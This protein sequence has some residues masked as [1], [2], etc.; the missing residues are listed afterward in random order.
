MA[1]CDIR[2]RMTSESIYIEYLPFSCDPATHIQHLYFDAAITGGSFKLAVNGNVTA[3]INLLTMPVASVNT[4]VGDTVGSE[5]DDVG[6]GLVVGDKVVFQ[7]TG[8]VLPAPLTVDTLYYV[9]AVPTVDSFKVSATSGGTAITITTVGTGTSSWNKLVANLIIN[10][11]TA[12]DALPN[13]ANGDIVA[14]G[15]LITDITLT[16]M[17][18]TALLKFFLIEVYSEALTQTV[19]NS[20]EHVVTEVTT[21]GSGWV[22]LSDD[23][24]AVDWELSV[25]TVDTTAISEYNRTEVPVA[26]S[27]SGTASFY[28]NKSTSSGEQFA[29]FLTPEKAW[30]ILRIYPEGKVLGKEVITLRA[31]VENFSETYPDHEKVEQ[32]LSFMRQGAWITRPTTVYS[33]NL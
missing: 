7:N 28:K 11:N 17:A 19:P 5:L 10:I 31:L 20:N 9:V 24:S 15:T 26:D 14:S 30:G 21:Q 16:A 1:V 33:V 8:G 4:F 29:L 6:H 13:L 23:V 12:L 25:E 2:E 27:V 18:A 32:E 3:A 22:R